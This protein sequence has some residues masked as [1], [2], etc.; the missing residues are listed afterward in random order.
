MDLSTSTRDWRFNQMVYSHKVTKW[1]EGGSTKDE[2]GWE[3][4]EGAT[5]KD[6]W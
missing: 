4:E 1:K 2:L 3:D 6:A 5:T